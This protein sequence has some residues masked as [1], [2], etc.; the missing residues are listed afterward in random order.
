MKYTPL[1]YRHL[2]RYEKENSDA[3]IKRLPESL[4]VKRLVVITTKETATASESFIMGVKPHI[5]VLT[6]GE[7]T[8]GK[9]YSIHKIRLRDDYLFLINSQMFNAKGETWSDSTGIKPDVS[10]NDDLSHKPGEPDEGMMKAALKALDGI[11]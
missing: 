4:N 1:P 3:M 10:A 11:I 2:P 9:P 6:V 5:K 8:R 7:A